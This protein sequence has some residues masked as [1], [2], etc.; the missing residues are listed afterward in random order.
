MTP[1]PK[2]SHALPVL[3]LPLVMMVVASCAFGGGGGGVPVEDFTTPVPVPTPIPPRPGRVVCELRVSYVHTTG[4][5]WGWAAANHLEVPP[6][7]FGVPGSTSP[8]SARASK[9]SAKPGQPAVLAMVYVDYKQSEL[10]VAFLGKQKNWLSDMIMAW[11]Y[12]D[13]DGNNYNVTSHFTSA[14]SF[15]EEPLPSHYWQLDGYL[16]RTRATWVGLPITPPETPPIRPDTRLRLHD[17]P[18]DG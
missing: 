12:A 10:H 18:S 5:G 11:H 9:C 7:T 15:V 8:D 13:A 2:T 14:A 3:L 6:F 16:W 17:H 1:K 4:T